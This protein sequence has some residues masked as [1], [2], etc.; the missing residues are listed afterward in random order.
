MLCAKNYLPFMGVEYEFVKMIRKGKKK[1]TF[2]VITYQAYNA[3][4]LI[5]SE[6][7]GIA[8][9]DE[10]K[11]CVVSDEIERQDSG[12]FGASAAQREL[13]DKILAMDAKAFIAFV[14]ASPRLRDSDWL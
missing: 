5:G 6:S 14:D 10:D 7:N 9:L 1:R 3:M 4:G 8:I 11:K 2:R 12:Y 13:M